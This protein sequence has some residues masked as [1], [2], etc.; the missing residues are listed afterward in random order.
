MGIWHLSVAIFQNAIDYN[1]GHSES[2]LAQRLVPRCELLVQY[3]KWMALDKLPLVDDRAANTS[4]TVS[5]GAGSTGAEAEAEGGGR[6]P[7]LTLSVFEAEAKVRLEFIKSAPLPLALS[8]K[9]QLAAVLVRK[10]C[11]RLL[12]AVRRSRNKFEKIEVSYFDVPVDVVHVTDYSVYVRRPADFST[13]RYRLEGQLPGDL[14]VRGLMDLGARP[15]KTVG[16]FLEEMRRVFSNATKYN[17]PKRA[18]DPVSD[19]VFLAAQRLS[20]RFE[21]LLCTTSVT[22]AELS[23]RRRILSKDSAKLESESL[24]VKE[25]ELQRDRDNY[26]RLIENKI[27]NDPSLARDRNISQRIKETEAQA[28]AHRAAQQERARSGA[29]EGPVGADDALRQDGSMEEQTH[30]HHRADASSGQTYRAESLAGYMAPQ[31]PQGL[32]TYDTRQGPIYMISGFGVGGTFPRKFAYQA[33]LKRRTLQCTR[34]EAVQR[35]EREQDETDAR[36][37]RRADRQK[38]HHMHIQ[39][40]TSRNRREHMRGGPGGAEDGGLGGVGRKLE[41]QTERE[42]QE[43]VQQQAIVGAPSAF[44]LKGGRGRLKLQKEASSV[45][46]VDEEEHGSSH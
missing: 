35:L 46:A 10:E 27:R 44:S 6:R 33:Q 21:A 17:Q 5:A 9:A 16:D 31:L 19:A 2:D 12:D 14:R 13:V 36:I 39:A 37:K 23:E 15:Y 29:M 42:E 43:R 3:T 4:D 38:E 26:A 24:A 41:R 25:R 20:E 40:S 34:L 22:L 11:C 28:E 7:I 18:T 30:T 45:F 1:G 8:G 32:G